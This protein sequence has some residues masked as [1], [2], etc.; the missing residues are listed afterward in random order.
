MAEEMFQDEVVRAT[1]LNRGSG[2]ILN[3]AARR[4]ITIIRNDEAFAL[5]RRDLAANWRR[6]ATSAL[7]LAEITVYAL[8]ATEHLE[9]E[10][11]WI[12]A[13]DRSQATEMVRELMAAYR[14]AVRDSGW[15][16]FDALLHEWSE[17]GWAAMNPEL[18]EAFEAE[19]EEVPI[20]L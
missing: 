5:L 15:D 11:E 10:Y 19:S 7:H 8:T 18:K 13:F 17:S 9:P 12:S 16:Q 1:D 6:E 14:K 2:E 20:A 4:P 3:R